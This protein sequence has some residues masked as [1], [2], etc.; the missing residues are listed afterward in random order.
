VGK[1]VCYDTGGLSLKSSKNMK[2]MKH[3]MAGAAA[4]IS[5]FLALDDL[6]LPIKA[7]C[8]LAIAENNIGSNAFRYVS[9][10]CL[11]E[12]TDLPFNFMIFHHISP[13]P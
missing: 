10:D 3:D 13:T 5:T 9:I 6:D 2:T 11:V 12:Y 7:E 8:W 4:A 1:G